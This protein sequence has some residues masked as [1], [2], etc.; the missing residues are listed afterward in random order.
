MASLSGTLVSMALRMAVAKMAVLPWPDCAFQEKRGEDCQSSQVRVR[1]RLWEGGGMGCVCIV[2]QVTVPSIHPS[3][4][5]LSLCGVVVVGGGGGGELT[6]QTK[7]SV[8][9]RNSSA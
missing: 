9:Y 8:R 3:I 4:T 2:S 6:N 5:I 1:L 7:L